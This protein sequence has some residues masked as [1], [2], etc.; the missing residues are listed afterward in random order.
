MI[1]YKLRKFL[2]ARH[3]SI[4]VTFFYVHEL[5]NLREPNKRPNLVVEVLKQKDQER[6][7]EVWPVNLKKIQKRLDNGDI[8][9]ISLVDDK[10]VGYQWVQKQG[11]HPF[12]QIGNTIKIEPKEF[13]CF[14]LRVANDFQNQGISTFMKWYALSEQKRVGYEKAWVYTDS[15]N[16]SN[17]RALEK[18]GFV[19]KR[20]I[21]SLKYDNSFLKLF[22]RKMTV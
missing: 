6:L 21:Y 10:V 19:L 11:Q 7:L 8:C 3:F 5:A 16:F 20:K 17:Q 22:S 12:Q 4:T 1:L 9:Y 14:D 2:K 13:W 15:K 18:S